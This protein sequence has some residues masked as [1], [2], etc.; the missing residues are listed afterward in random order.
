[1]LNF[2]GALITQIINTIFLVAILYL[3]YALFYRNPKNIKKRL[4]IIEKRLD[5]MEQR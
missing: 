3:F 4:E 1:V 5:D 2:D